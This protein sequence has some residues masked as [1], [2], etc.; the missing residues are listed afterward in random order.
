M[1]EVVGAHDALQRFRQY[2]RRQR[3][4]FASEL[5]AARVESRTGHRRDD[6]GKI[7]PAADAESCHAADRLD[8]SPD[9]R[10][11]RRYGAERNQVVAWLCSRHPSE[12][13]PDGANC[14]SSF[15]SRH[16]C[17]V[18]A[19]TTSTYGIDFAVMKFAAPVPVRVLLRV[20]TVFVDTLRTTRL[21]CRLWGSRRTGWDMEQLSWTDD[22]MLRAEKPE[23]P[24]QIQM[25]LIYDQSTAP[26]GKVTFKRILGEI[27]AR[28][29]LAPTFRRR[30]TELPG[31][32]HMPY[33]VDDPN[34]DL[35]YHVRH[36]ALPQPGDWRQL[37]IQI[38]RIHGRQLD[39]RR[40]PWEMT[41]IEGLNSIPGV[42]KGSFAISLK[43][44]HCV[45]DG[46]ESVELMAAMHD[47]AFDSPRP[48]PPEK[49]WKPAN[50][51]V[52][53]GPRLADSDQRRAPPIARGKSLDSQC[54]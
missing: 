47:L 36:I 34:F 44:H 24:M 7:R 1:C 45:V 54:L 13:G 17:S 2:R 37:C 42:P 30:L 6:A 8:V 52:D 3:E 22:M 14:L 23:T 33:W 12:A 4:L 11:R 50:A 41:V 20:V 49:P 40:P 15:H 10:C 35:E 21:A 26:D 18:R 43:L 39:L 27:D 19:T 29:H 9:H 25:L 16:R 28:L 31:G 38:A 46:M 51:A 5:V 48:A 32:L 53:S